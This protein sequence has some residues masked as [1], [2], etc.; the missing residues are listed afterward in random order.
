MAIAIRLARGRSGILPVASLL[1]GPKAR[2]LTFAWLR[3]CC[4][5]CTS[6]AVPNSFMPRLA[7]ADDSK[8]YEEQVGAGTC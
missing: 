8:A 6:V 2:L 5:F 4:S 1:T 3:S 7:E